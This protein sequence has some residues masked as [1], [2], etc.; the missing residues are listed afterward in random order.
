MRKISIDSL[1]IKNT[2]FK[3][4]LFFPSQKLRIVYNWENVYL[5]WRL[6]IF[7]IYCFTF[8]ASYKI[9]KVTRTL[10]IRMTFSDKI[11]YNFGNEGN[12]VGLL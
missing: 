11:S 12:P 5:P 3:S 7:R 9:K 2:E 1:A 6:Y 8:T 4:E 10:L